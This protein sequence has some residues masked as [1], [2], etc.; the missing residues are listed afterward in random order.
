MATLNGRT[1]ITNLGNTGIQPCFLDP[2]YIP[3]GYL[4]PKGDEIDVTSLQTAL[5]AKIYNPSKAARWYPIYNLEEIKSNTEKKTVQTMATGQKHVVREG[6]NDWGFQYQ[7]GGLSLHKILRLFNGSNFDFIFVDNDAPSW[8]MIGIAGSSAT[9]L[10]AIPSDG[11]YFWADPWDP[12]DGSKIAAY[13]LNFVFK[14]TYINDYVATVSGSF[15]LPT[16][17]PG[18]IDV[19]LV[20]SAT[21]NATTGSFN[22]CIVSPLGV[23]IG[24]KYSSVLAAAAVWTAKNTAT[25]VTIVPSGATWVPSTTPG[26]PGYFTVVLPTTAPPYPASGTVTFGLVGTDVLSATPYGVAIEPI[27]PVA[28][29][30]S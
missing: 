6:Y 13:M 7:A 22:I 14:S 19:N 8:N 2:K 25:G 1:C 11:G 5:A 28:I 12:N 17:L 24:A 10:K 4:T 3:I 23:D 29:T 9:K 21:V 15:D 16:T 26:V 20:A 27:A 30:R 18:L